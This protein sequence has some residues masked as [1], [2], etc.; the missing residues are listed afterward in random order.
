MS[1]STPLALALACLV[2]CTSGLCVE[3]GPSAPRGRGLHSAAPA[4]LAQVRRSPS[5]LRRV[6]ERARRMPKHTKV[7]LGLCAAG[8]ILFFA[9]IWAK[10]RL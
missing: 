1:A 10:S 4:V 2:H 5:K 8:L 3:A 6:V 9:G 7:V